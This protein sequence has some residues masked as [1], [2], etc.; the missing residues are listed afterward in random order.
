MHRRV[1][2]MFQQVKISDQIPAPAEIITG[3]EPRGSI[4]GRGRGRQS[5][6]RDVPLSDRATATH[7]A[8]WHL[9]TAP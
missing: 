1:E 6:S 7:S 5:R 4:R 9:V 8:G 3:T 2:V